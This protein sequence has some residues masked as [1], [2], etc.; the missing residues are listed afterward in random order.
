MS[1]LESKTLRLRLAR[2]QHMQRSL[3][4]NSAEAKLPTQD[5]RLEDV[6]AAREGA[7]REP[8]PGPPGQNASPTSGAGH[9]QA[10]LPVD[11]SSSYLI[12]RSL[13]MVSPEAHRWQVRLQAG[14]E[15][16]RL[17]NL[18]PENISG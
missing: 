13:E 9:R 8:P 2:P 18:S 16:S 7:P 10:S 1:V 17:G 14:V 6:S 12:T 5:N 11:F 15:T 3:R 4:A